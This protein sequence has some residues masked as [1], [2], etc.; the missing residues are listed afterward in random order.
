MLNLFDILEPESF[1]RD[2]DREQRLAKEFLKAFAREVSRPIFRN[3][4]HN[5][6]YVPTQV[7]TEFV[8]FEL[9]GYDG[10]PFDGIR[11]RSSRNSRPSLVLFATQSQCLG[12]CERQL[13][14]FVEGSLTREELAKGENLDR[15]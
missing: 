10:K 5:F 13:V 15:L 8:R 1:F 6:E 12:L 2:E 14:R 11:Y 7:F 3:G 4:R 9:K